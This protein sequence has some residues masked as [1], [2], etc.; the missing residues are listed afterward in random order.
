MKTFLFS[1]LAALLLFVPNA[2]AHT[3]ISETIPQ[4][5]STV[6]E[7]VQQIVLTFEGKIEEGSTFKAVAADG[8]EYTPQSIS[9]VDGVLT[10]TFDPALPNETYTVKWNTISQDGHPLSGEFGFTVDAPIVE[11]PTEKVEDES[12]EQE[13]VAP[14]ETT[15][16]VNDE[17]AEKSNSP[18]MLVVGL[19]VIII[20]ISIVALAKRKKA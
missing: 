8:T 2:A 16:Q 15:E 20:I 5:G 4:D 19:L 9:L 11:Q 13:T 6:T 7:N 17:D 1:I 12:D 3:Y 10:G 14:V 18:L